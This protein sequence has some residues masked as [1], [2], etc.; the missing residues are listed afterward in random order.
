MLSNWVGC[1]ADHSSQ[2]RLHAHHVGILRDRHAEVALLDALKNRHVDRPCDHIDLVRAVLVAADVA[3]GGERA[4]RRIAVSAE[5]DVDLGMRL[6][7]RRIDRLGL[8]QIALVVDLGD[9]LRARRHLLQGVGEAR[10][11]MVDR[12]EARNARDADARLVAEQ[13]GDGE[14]SLVAGVIVV[15]ADEQ[16]PMRLRRIRVERQN[17]DFRLHAG[18]DRGD[19]SV[20]VARRDRDAFD[21]FR[22]ELIDGSGFGGSVPIG[23]ALQLGRR[24]E[25]RRL[26]LEPGI[27]P[28]EEFGSLEKH[29]H[30]VVLLGVRRFRRAARRSG[31]RD[32]RRKR[33]KY[34]SR[35]L[36]F[37]LPKFCWLQT[38]GPSCSASIRAAPGRFEA[39]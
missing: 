6:Q 24:P 18:V 35:R 10:D 33:G 2:H 34:A 25:R 22:H 12:V 9:D 17:R 23:G 28:V 19:Q 8:L 21:P 32:R 5:D 31:E 16:Q 13:L 14:A 4:G 30:A 36:H 27:G 38:I 11:A 3:G 39:Q 29:D 7:H 26:V 15:G 20:R 37:P 1:A